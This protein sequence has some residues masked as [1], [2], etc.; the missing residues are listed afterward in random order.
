MKRIFILAALFWA[1]MTAANADNVTKA[2]ALEIAAQFMNQN[3][4]A[5]VGAKGTDGK[6]VTATIAESTDGHYVVNAGNS[7]V[8]VAADDAV[9]QQVLG[10]CTSGSFDATNVPAGM[11]DMLNDYDREIA[12]IKANN[13]K[14]SEASTATSVTRDPILL[15]T[16]QWDQLEPYYNLCPKDT[17]GL[18]EHFVT[19]CGATALAEIMYYHKY[20]TSYKWDIM[21]PTYDENSSEESCTAVAQLMSDVGVASKMEYGTV[22]N[23][24]EQDLLAAITGTFGYSDDAVILQRSKFTCD[25]WEDIIYKNLQEYGPLQYNGYGHAFVL[26]G[27]KDGYFHFNWGWSGVSNDTYF[28]LSS[29]TPG[30]QGTGASS[31]HNYTAHQRAIFNIHP[32]DGKE[33]AWKA[34]EPTQPVN[35]EQLELTSFTLNTAVLTAGLEDSLAVSCTFKNPTSEFIMEDVFICLIDDNKNAKA[36]CM[37][38]FECQGNDTCSI[39]KTVPLTLATGKYTI[40][41]L[42]LNLTGDEQLICKR[43]ITAVPVLSA[44]PQAIFTSSK[45]AYVKVDISDVSLIDSVTVQMASS[46]PQV[47]LGETTVEASNKELIIPVALDPAIEPETEIVFI[48]K[49]QINGYTF[50]LAYKGLDIFKTVATIITGIEPVI[51]DATATPR[52]R[53]EIKDGKVVIIRN[54]KQYNAVGQ[55]Q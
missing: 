37:N 48:I 55:E 44:M 28:T 39:T 22:S 35:T 54:G 25:E 29:L 51:S 14:K 7:F 31:S 6:T 33:H 23:S 43:Q 42:N 52:V 36:I 12:Y 50:P 53:K 17:T 8:I 18:R 2:Q 27:Y 41:L 49:E 4:M 1:A 3:G 47:A 34:G 45:Q 19:G 21:T 5:K 24:N 11:Q 15:E 10:Y 9:T 46:N 30:E 40:Y 26:D 20:P 13:I 32:K 16:P 38:H